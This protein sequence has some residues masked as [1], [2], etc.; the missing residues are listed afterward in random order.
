M[1]AGRQRSAARRIRISSSATRISKRLSMNPTSIARNARAAV[2]LDDDEPLALQLAQRLAH[3]HVAHLVARGEPVDGQ[4]GAESD[5]AGDDV[6]P[7]AAGD[8]DGRRG[9][10]GFDHMH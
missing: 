5:R 6:V 9:V 2:G 7:D 3:R 10:A 4:P 1:S 8:V